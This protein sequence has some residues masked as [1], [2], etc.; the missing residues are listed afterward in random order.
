MNVY[1][2]LEHRHNT[3][4]R[5][6]ASACLFCPLETKY[7]GSGSVLPRIVNTRNFALPL[8]GTNHNFHKVKLGLWTF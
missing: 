4:T 1:V 8:P 7:S 2:T 6:C 5:H 3:W